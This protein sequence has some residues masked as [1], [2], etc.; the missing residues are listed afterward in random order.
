MSCGTRTAESTFKPAQ[1][2]KT[3][4]HRGQKLHTSLPF[5]SPHYC[6]AAELF[7]ERIGIL[8]ILLRRQKSLNVLVNASAAIIEAALLTST[9][10]L[11]QKVCLL[12]ACFVYVPPSN[13]LKP[14]RRSIKLLWE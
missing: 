13:S 9:P 5:I 3:T 14:N 8:N 10:V 7:I 6:S 12:L 2:N 1:N 4:T 11:L